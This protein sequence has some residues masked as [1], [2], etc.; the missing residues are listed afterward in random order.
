MGR[1]CNSRSRG[2]GGKKTNR[3]PTGRTPKGDGGSGGERN[4]KSKGRQRAREGN[5]I[6][7]RRICKRHRDVKNVRKVFQENKGQSLSKTKRE[8]GG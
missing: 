4:G 2:T 5:A 3:P 6:L 8:E 1:R 7:Q